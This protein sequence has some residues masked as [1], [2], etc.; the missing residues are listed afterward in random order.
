MQAA[1]ALADWSLQNKS[2]FTNKT[3]LELGSGVGLTGIIVSKF[4]N[5]SNTYL[6]D[7]H[8]SVLEML[9]ANV[10]L[11]FANA[12][13]KVEN[14]SSSNVLEIIMEDGRCLSALDLP[15]GE[16]DDDFA[17]SIDPDV[18]FASDIVYDPELFKDL[19]YALSNFLKLGKCKVILAC[20]E[21]NP[22]TLE[23]FLN[24]LKM[25]LD[26][27]ELPE[28]TPKYLIWSKSDIPIKL[29]LIKS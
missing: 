6:S 8:S 25:R 27:E 14:R 21:R 29:F 2:E 23:M 28:V 3:V 26:Y 19:I 15:W 16:M 11:N 1:L 7:C 17:K 9:C 12:T 18:I 4:C 20:T 10:R 24:E 22:E 13:V 5:P